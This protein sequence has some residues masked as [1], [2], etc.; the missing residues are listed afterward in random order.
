MSPVFPRKR[1]TPEPRGRVT[2]VTTV[3]GFQ[4]LRLRRAG[5]VIVLDPEDFV[6]LVSGDPLRTNAYA[7]AQNGYLGFPVAKKIRLPESWAKRV[8]RPGR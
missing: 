8:H 4:E 2:I 1:G 6:V 5:R 7:F 3:S